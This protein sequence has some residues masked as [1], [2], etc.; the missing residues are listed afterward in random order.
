[1]LPSFGRA[2]EPPY[3][4]R[5]TACS[6]LI[7][8]SRRRQ[9]TLQERLFGAA[10]GP[11]QQRHAPR[12]RLPAAF[13]VG[14]PDGVGYQRWIETHAAARWS[15]TSHNAAADGCIVGCQR[16]RGVLNSTIETLHDLDLT[17]HAVSG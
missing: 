14:K 5:A 12:L 11:L 1:M 6:C 8:L 3:I 16:L 4:G 10:T 17:W 13:D 9:R 15:A 2:L 7:V